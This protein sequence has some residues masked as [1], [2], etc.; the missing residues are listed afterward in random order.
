VAQH[1]LLWISIRVDLFIKLLPPF[2]E[3]REMVLMLFPV[4]LKLIVDLVLVVKR[5][6]ELL[7][8]M[9]VLFPVIDPTFLVLQSHVARGSSPV[10]GG[11]ILLLVAEKL[12]FGN[13]HAGWSMGIV[14]S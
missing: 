6:E 12:D 4:F 5:L 8:H 14:N 13:C 9:L 11:E 3:A 7:A 10:L 1:L 2:I